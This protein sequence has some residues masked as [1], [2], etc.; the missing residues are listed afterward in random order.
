MGD[1]T[2]ARTLSPDEIEDRLRVEFLDES[3]DRL[4][5]MNDIL[6]NVAAGTFADAA[7]IGQLHVEA[8]NFRGVG[9]SFGYP[10]ITL[11]AHRMDD[12][13]LG[14]TRLQAREIADLQAFTDR[15]AE[16]VDRPNQPDV[17]EVNRIIRSLPTRYVF[18]ITDVVVKDVEVMLV[19]PSKVMSKKV[20]TELAACG[21]KVVTVHD[22]IES[23]SLAVRMPPDMIVASMV[24]DGLSGLD[25]IRGLRAMTVTHHVHMALLTSLERGNPALKEIPGDVAVIRVGAGFSDDLAT[26][27]TRFNVG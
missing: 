8:H 23:I 7:A 13:M 15:I 24:M 21:F 22:P 12:Y 14:L 19:T 5:R 2:M 18:D 11:I 26:A 10:G 1:L 17:A 4:E 27:V 9:T 6:K 3:H 16:L 20:G 25:L